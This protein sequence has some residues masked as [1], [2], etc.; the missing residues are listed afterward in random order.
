MTA[1]W[2][3]SS[4]HYIDTLAENRW[5]DYNWKYSGNRFAYWDQ[6][7]SKTEK[8][9]ELETSGIEGQNKLL[10]EDTARQKADFSFYLHSAPPLPAEVLGRK[11]MNGKSA[12]NGKKEE[13][14]NGPSLADVAAFS[15]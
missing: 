9:A 7:F 6:G 2:P 14:R 10:D 1:L 8:M 13:E 15:V 11:L 4:L 3:G 5:E 12:V